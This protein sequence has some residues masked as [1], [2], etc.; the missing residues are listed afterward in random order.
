MD[1]GTWWRWAVYRVLFRFW[2]ALDSLRYRVEDRM[3]VRLM[4][5]YYRLGADRFVEL[6]NPVLRKYGLEMAKETRHS[7]DRAFYQPGDDTPN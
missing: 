6:I 4:V 5:L 7:P 2:L 1:F 3:N